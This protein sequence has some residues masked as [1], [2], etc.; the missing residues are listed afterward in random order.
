MTQTE[1]S[2]HGRPGSRSSFLVRSALALVGTSALTSGLGF[3]FWVVAAR[4]TTATEVGEAATAIAAMSLLAPFASLGFGTLL[5]ARL[6]TMAEGRSQLV[7]T[8][9]LASAVVGAVLALVCAELLP[10]SFLGIPTLGGAPGATTV[11]VLGVSAHGVGLVLDQALLSVSGG[12]PQ[13]GRNAVLALGKLA[14]LVAAALALDELDSLTVYES[15]L[16]GNVLSILLMGAWLVRT[17]R[18]P[19]RGLRPAA[20]VLS[21]LRL[22]AAQHHALNL[23]L[24]VPYF[25]MPMIASATLGSQDAGYLYATWSVAGIVFVLPIALSTALFASGARDAARFTTEF[26]L[27]LRWSLLAALAANLAVLPLGGWVLRVFGEEYADNGRTAL[28]FLCLAGLGLVIKDHHVTI[29]RMTGDVGREAGLVWVLTALEILGAA[30]GALAGG[31]TGLAVGWL[32]AVAVEAVVY[33]PLV[34]RASRGRLPTP[35]AG[36]AS[37]S[38]ILGP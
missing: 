13:L 3:V 37:T 1:A 4:L 16:L 26:R 20:G 9:A 7:V 30:L 25:A 34:L 2:G 35:D 17:H 18:V 33:G 32:A 6:P 22:D 24:S 36:D 23:A 19:W 28:I 8:A 5:I 31:L 14:L 29:A 15:W 27:T 38:G 10:D 11:F 12:G 21:G